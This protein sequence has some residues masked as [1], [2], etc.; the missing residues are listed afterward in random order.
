MYSINIYYRCLEL[1]CYG[2]CGHLYKC[3]CLDTS[4]ICKHIHRVHCLLSRNV[5]EDVS[6]KEEHLEDDYHLNYTNTT[7][8]EQVQEIAKFKKTELDVFHENI[9]RLTKLVNIPVVKSLRLGN[10]NRQLLDLIT[11]CEAVK[12]FSDDDMGVGQAMSNTNQRHVHPNS[13]LET[14]IKPGKFHRTK[15]AQNKGTVTPLS[16]T[17][18]KNTFT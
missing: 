17:L 15:K 3:N 8:N 1:A 12:K 9:N 10:I 7:K 18:F 6:N 4:N 11:Q 16:F 2:L 14:Q 13:K 5:T